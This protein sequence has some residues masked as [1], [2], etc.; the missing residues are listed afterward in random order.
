MEKFPL[1]CKDLVAGKED[2]VRQNLRSIGTYLT[3]ADLIQ[4]ES[5]KTIIIK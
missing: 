2:R 1:G 4:P 5:Q 3:I